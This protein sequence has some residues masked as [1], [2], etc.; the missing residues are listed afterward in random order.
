MKK[1]DYI[2]LLLRFSQ[3]VFSAHDIM[4]LWGDTNSSAVKSRISYYVKNGSLYRIRRGLYAKDTNY[5]RLECATKVYTPSYISFETVLAAAG[6]IFQYYKQIF[7]ASYVSREIVT[8]E[9]T[10]AFRRIQENILTNSLGIIDRQTY[11][12]ASPERAFLD[13][14]Y[15]SKDYHFDNLSV[16]NWEKVAEILPIYTGNIRMEKKVAQYKSLAVGEKS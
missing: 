8:A 15:L 5:D 12:I 3:T 16:L 14:L 1:G 2:P 7:V 6:I 13:V 10:I 9:S 4:L 11:S